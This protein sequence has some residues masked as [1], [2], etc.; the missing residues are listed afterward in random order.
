MI[1]YDVKAD[2]PAAHLFN[3]SVYIPSP[4]K[5]GQKLGLANWIPG[6]YLIRDFARLIISIDAFAGVDASQK[7]A[8]EKIAKIART[9]FRTQRDFEIDIPVEF[10]PE[11]AG[12]TEM[13]AQ[14]ATWEE[15][16]HATIYDEGDIVR[17][18]R[19][20]LDLARQFMRAPHMDE[21]LVELCQQV[22]IRIARDEVK[23]E[24]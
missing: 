7:I 9:L 17:S 6:S 2:N 24:V 21:A 20:T 18:L 10:N 11:F 12:L 15:M 19:R 23:Q 14:G 22:E 16:R 13:W 8:L 3:V 1:T 4:D 5:D